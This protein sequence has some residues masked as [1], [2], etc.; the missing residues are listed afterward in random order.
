[1]GDAMR[2]SHFVI[3]PNAGEGIEWRAQNLYSAKVPIVR[4]LKHAQA[5]EIEEETFLVAPPDSQME[6]KPLLTRVG[7]E[8][9]VI[10]CDRQPVARAKRAWAAPDEGCDPAFRSVAWGEAGEPIR[11]R[12][13]VEPG[14][15]RHVVVGLCEGEHAEAGKRVLDLHVDGA[16]S[17]RGIDLA[18]T[19]GKNKGALFAFNARDHDGDGV[20]EIR[21]E[22]NQ[23]SG[24]RNVFVNAIWAFREEPPAR[25]TILGGEAC[26][27]AYAFADCG[28]APLPGRQY[29]TIVRLTNNGSDTRTYSP[30]WKIE[31]LDR[32]ERLG[33]K[34]G[35]LHLGHN[36]RV[37]ASEGF[38]SLEEASPH[39]RFAKLSPVVLAPGETKQL[40]ITVNR[41]G[42]MGEALSPDKAGELRDGAIRYWN[43]AALP[44]DKI[45]VP[46][47]GIQA[48]I[49]SSIRN[50]YQARDIR[51][52][53]P[54]F[55]VGPT[56]YRCLWIVDGAFLL[57]T[58]TM[59][60]RKEET[61][62]G[63]AYMLSFQGADGGF[64]VKA[65]YWKETG[66]IL[67]A[68]VRHALLT[69]DKEWLRGQWP[70]LKR[71][72][73]FINR[74][75]S[76]E[77]TVDL[78]ALEY[79]LLPAG[80]IDG[81][82]GYHGKPE[83]SN[84]YWS[85]IGLKAM[86]DAARWIEDAAAATEWGADY[87]DFY[88]SFRKAAKRDMKDDPHGNQYLPILMADAMN[89]VPQR[90]QWSFCHAVYPGMLF[91]KGDPLVEGNLSMLRATK[92][93]GMVLGTGWV[94]DGI[95]TYFASFYGHALLWEGHGR[96]AAE[97]LYDF[98]NHAA[99]NMAWREEQMPQG[100][101][102]QE[103]GDMPHNW[104][105]AEFIRLVVHSIA[106]DRGEELHLCEGLPREW[107]FPGA[108]VSL[109]GI[110]TPFGELA[111]EL[112]I[113]DEG[114]SAKLSVNKLTGSPCAKIVFH[115]EGWSDVGG[116]LEF[117]GDMPIE[118]IVSLW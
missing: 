54:A 61:R 107:V 9:Q 74:L 44:Y 85:L 19:V 100:K 6:I 58:A 69:Q 112:S 47:S 117:A 4:T 80:D 109:R 38:L 106:L 84:I 92:A 96:E 37:L 34:R 14:G 103:F 23:A 102:D 48:M 57:E 75:R 90:A 10:G 29:I 71:A 21:I 115:R 97:S 49:D 87:E 51:D 76:A 45:Q 11:Y 62:A 39:C 36:T 16:E 24:D 52:G 79:R 17:K 15:S 65:R 77:N 56:C 94:K 40:V 5:I 35:V 82:I 42:Y 50:I 8:E 20:I 27:L 63:M 67:W 43:S 98:A 99:P 78:E 32:F 113:S 89:E 41:H 7:G 95:W 28:V 110:A 22:A 33:L 93:E 73:D 70:T 3:T 60:G 64:Q 2:H 81:G 104:A 12:L 55:H 31:R 30:V 72:V 111:L 1:M 66:I 68:V 116:M 105:S 91:E 88:A 118:T 26:E 18:G 86:V 13:M 46:D 53:L 25:E 108:V 59:L 101:G 83:Y 114:N